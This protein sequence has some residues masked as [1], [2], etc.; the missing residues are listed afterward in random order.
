MYTLIV[1]TFKANA[2]H[3]PG[4][5]HFI[6]LYHPCTKDFKL[7]SLSCFFHTN[8]FITISCETHVNPLFIIHDLRHSIIL[9]HIKPLAQYPKP[10]KH[11]PYKAKKT[12]SHCTVLPSTSLRRDVLAQ[13]SPL[14]LCEG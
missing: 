6:S 4:S 11:Y 1:L 12:I 3:V 8:H 5:T 10:S 9:I 14:R 13:A 7:I 2:F